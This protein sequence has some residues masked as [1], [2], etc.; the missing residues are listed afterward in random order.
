MIRFDKVIL[1]RTYKEIVKYYHSEIWNPAKECISE[2]EKWQ[3]LLIEL[4]PSVKTILPTDAGERTSEKAQIV[5]LNY[6]KLRSLYGLAHE[7]GEQVNHWCHELGVSGNV[8][9]EEDINKAKAVLT[10]LFEAFGKVDAVDIAHDNLNGFQKLEQAVDSF[11]AFHDFLVMRSYHDGVQWGNWTFHDITGNIGVYGLQS[12]AL[13]ESVLHDTVP[14]DL[15]V[16]GLMESEEDN[17]V[18]R[19]Y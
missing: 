7:I 13:W 8:Q 17:K 2:L 16:S 19:L 5:L 14:T 4:M 1:P 12:D 18:V 15:N 11:V 3:K 9:D 10:D 6:L